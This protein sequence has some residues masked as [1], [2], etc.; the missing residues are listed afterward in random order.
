MYQGLWGYWTKIIMILCNIPTSISYMN[1]IYC[2][3]PNLVKEKDYKT[4]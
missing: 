3:I 2:E 1:V 4:K